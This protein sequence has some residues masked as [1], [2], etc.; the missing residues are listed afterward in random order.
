MSVPITGGC[1]CGAVRYALA[2][3]R[4]PRA[5]CC[6]CRDCQTWTGSAFSQQAVV[7]EREFALT[8]GVPVLFELTNPSGSISR[9]YIC[10]NCHTRLY[11]TNSARPGIVLI[12]AGTL[13]DSDQ[14][15]AVLH[16]W[17]KRKQPWIAFA[18]DVPA[19]EKSAPVEVFQ[20]LVMGAEQ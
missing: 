5:Y 7:R 19:F 15:E 16:I 13:D 11:N 14:L 10:G 4:L 1:R 2:L 8:A 18:K 12:R 3:D 9:Q 6:H 20:R 17:A